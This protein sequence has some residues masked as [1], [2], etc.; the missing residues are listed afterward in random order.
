MG[1]AGWGER[2]SALTENRR[3]RPELVEACSALFAEAFAWHGLARD[4]VV[5]RPHRGPLRRRARRR[6]PPFGL[7]TL[8]SKKA[9]SAEALAE[10]VRRMLDTPGEYPV[11][12]RRTHEVRPVR[13][14]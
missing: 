10:G 9:D 1:R 5:V 6:F 11:L 14:R 2:G 13:R 4:E 8:A 12:D 3:S 7:W